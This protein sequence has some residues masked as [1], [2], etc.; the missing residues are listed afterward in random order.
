M[1]APRLKIERLLEEIDDVDGLYLHAAYRLRKLITAH[2][3]EDGNKRTAWA[4][5]LEY[6]ER[7]SEE[8]ADMGET[9]SGC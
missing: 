2:F 7:N 4:V 5:T 8:P 6:L 1:V 3:F 9:S